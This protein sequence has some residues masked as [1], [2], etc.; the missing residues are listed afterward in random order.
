MGE[1]LAFR[2]I[3]ISVVILA[4]LFVRDAYRRGGHWLPMLLWGVATGF[5]IELAIMRVAD[6]SIPYYAYDTEHFVSALGIP[7][8]VSVG[9][10]L[11]LYSSL[12]TAQQWSDQ[13][14][15]HALIAGGLA[16]NID[17]SLEGI[18]QRLGFWVWSWPVGAPSKRI[19]FFG[20]P[21]D[22]FTGWFGI[23]SL[24]A[25]FACWG[26]RFSDR[27]LTEGW[28]KLARQ[29]VPPVSAV[30]TMLT[31]CVVRSPI[32]M[33][34]RVLGADGTGHVVVLA[35]LM[36]ASVWALLSSRPRLSQNRIVLALVLFVQAYALVM[37]F[38]H[39]AL[40]DSS[41]LKL[42]VSVNAV[43]GASI[44]LLPQWTNLR[45][46]LPDVLK[47]AHAAGSTQSD[48]GT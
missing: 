38:A 20:I 41:G 32:V 43:L 1:S 42:I 47:M 46:R 29:V 24:F 36:L 27:L 11:I 39:P 14:L 18:A 30:L 35:G 23:V 9:W 28:L 22:N 8:W 5:C 26:F 19:D 48:S 12:W 33:L 4:P 15:K 40:A 31:L 44:H 45:Y 13:P 10:G 34:Y 2:A 21:F 25:L 7:V 17:L 37:V 16:V 3:E 6:H